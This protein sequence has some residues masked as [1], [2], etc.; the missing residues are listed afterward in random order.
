MTLPQSMLDECEPD[1]AGLL[2]FG[3]PIDSFTLNELKVL[4]VWQEKRYRKNQEENLSILKLS[5]T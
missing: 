1:I 4:I 5:F 3:E 2:I